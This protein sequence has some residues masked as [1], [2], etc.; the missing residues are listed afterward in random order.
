[1][2]ISR[3]AQ[4]VT[5]ARAAYDE[6][7]A[8]LGRLNDLGDEITEEDDA[9]IPALITETAAR[10]DTL[11]ELVAA[12]K[13]AAAFAVVVD[14]DEVAPAPERS[15]PIM[16]TSF[17]IN[18]RK[19]DNPLDMRTMNYDTPV[20]DIHARIHTALEN[21][22]IAR[23]LGATRSES[24]MNTVK[25]ADNGSGRLGRYV[26]AH[27]SPDYGNAWNK[28]TSNR[29]EELTSEERQ[30]MTNARAASLTDGEGGFAVPADLDPML[31]NSGD[32]ATNPFRQIATVKQ[33]ISDVYQKPATSQI[34]LAFEAE[35]A[36]ANDIAPTITRTTITPAKL[37]GVIPFSIELQGDWASF[38]EEM[39]GL[40]ADS[41]DLAEATAFATGSGTNAPVGIVTAL[42]LNT[43]V[44]VSMTTNGAF[45][46]EDIYLF[47]QA[48]PP[49]FRP[50]ASW[51]MENTNLN[52]VRQFGTSSNYHGFT[53]DLSAE[54]ISTILG[55]NVYESSAMASTLSTAGVQNSVV[56]GDFKNYYIVDRVG[57]LRVELV[58][59]LFN[60]STNLPDGQRAW[61]AWCRVGADS[62]NDNAFILGQNASS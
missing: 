53:V 59:H 55:K 34:A 52:R 16:A 22:D 23:D 5:D 47:Q 3:I 17:N 39:T 7:F 14:A 15:E 28:I 19:D 60:T 26:A 11:D 13:R 9:R 33:T 27:L 48:L 46:I 36:E 12:E 32:G 42:D 25:A 61:Y 18:T 62:V 45:G 29:M 54:G 10:Q 31:I 40:L 37:Q 21:P 44:E 1:V 43:N 58:P 20:S 30:A 51:I 6:S 50:N 57:S 24:I 38:R 41:K 8:E 2:S 35:A 4:Q 56:F 49:R